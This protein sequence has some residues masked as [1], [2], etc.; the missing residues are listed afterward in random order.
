MA[1]ADIRR[2]SEVVI[3]NEL[4]SRLTDWLILVARGG[5]DNT[6]EEATVQIPPFVVVQAR[7]AEKM[8]TGEPT[9][10][11]SLAVG[12]VTELTDMLPKDHAAKLQELYNALEDI[13]PGFDEEQI[14]RLHGI[15]IL[16]AN[17]FEDAEKRA[18][19]DII[20]CILGCSGAVL[21]V[22]EGGIPPLSRGIAWMYR[23]DITSLAN[24]CALVPTVNLATASLVETVEIISGDS[25]I[26]T[27][28]LQAGAASP[29]DSG[30]GN[31]AD[32]NALTNNRH[33]AR[34]G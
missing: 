29:A 22:P 24:L 5:T 3:R 34:I 19:G 4:A 27:Y 1:E 26:R 18:R 10:T 25:Q 15:D 31:P 30:H 2:K 14:Y 16:D 20:S 32:Y 17:V 33:W 8:I 23:P 7:A 9:W 28:E 6:A 13:H 21:P 11:V 12:Y